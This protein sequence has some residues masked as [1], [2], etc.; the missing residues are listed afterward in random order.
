MRKSKDREN[1]QSICNLLDAIVNT[2]T[3]HLPFSLIFIKNLQSIEQRKLNFQTEEKYV[4]IRTTINHSI[5]FF[6]T[7]IVFSMG[8]K[9]I[10][11]ELPKNFIPFFSLI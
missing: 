5:S 2:L 9:N 6:H 10:P 3:F 4:E 8:E 11:D 1:K 7:L